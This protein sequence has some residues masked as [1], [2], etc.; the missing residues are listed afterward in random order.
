MCGQGQLEVT[1]GVL[2]PAAQ[3][4]AVGFEAFLI[5][6]VVDFVVGNDQR[7]GAPGDR[8]RVTDVVAVLS[9]PLAA[10]SDTGA[11]ISIG[12]GGQAAFSRSA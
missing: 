4:L 3:V 10:G 8:L 6:P 1:E 7:A 9:G 2:E 5:K 12:G 11:E